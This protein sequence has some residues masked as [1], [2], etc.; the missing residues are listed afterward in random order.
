MMLKII[1]THVPT[2]GDF[3]I[4]KNKKVLEMMKDELGGKHMRQFVGVKPK[5]YTSFNSLWKSWWEGKTNWKSI[6]QGYK[7]QSGYIYR[8][9]KIIANKD[10][11]ERQTLKGSM[12]N[13]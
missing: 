10:T 13:F 4:G 8:P 12:E 3:P 6:C 2:S 7:I 1:L 5:C 11:T 9:V